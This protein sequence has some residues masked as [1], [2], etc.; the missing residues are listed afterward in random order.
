MRSRK[1]EEIRRNRVQ[2]NISLQR[3][4]VYG[5]IDRVIVIVVAAAKRVQVIRVMFSSVRL[6]TRL[7]LRVLNAP[8]RGYACT[9]AHAGWRHGLSK[10]CWWPFFS[11]TPAALA[12]HPQNPCL[13]RLVSTSAVA[14][15]VLF[16]CVRGRP[17]RLSLSRSFSRRR[18]AS[19]SAVSAA[20]MSAAV[21]FSPSYCS[22]ERAC[23]GRERG[24]RESARSAE[25]G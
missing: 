22:G 21:S 7:R 15:D 9:V 17:V 18:A 8:R 12:F 1:G 11:S 16:C 20:G 5:W 25:G 19:F 2:A 14:A 4:M 3:N 6:R 23:W 13:A 24:E 10:S